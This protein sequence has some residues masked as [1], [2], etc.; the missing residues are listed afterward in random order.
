MKGMNGDWSLGL[1]MIPKPRFEYTLDESC[2]EELDHVAHENMRVQRRVRP[3]V[4][5]FYGL[6]VEPHTRVTIALALWQETHSSHLRA[7][8]RHVVG[9]LSYPRS[10]V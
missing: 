5:N 2:A 1:G 9:K 7:T 3:G 8:V 6:L 10:N 4:P